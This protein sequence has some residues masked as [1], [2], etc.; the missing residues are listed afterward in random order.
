M[1]RWHAA[2]PP[3]AVLFDM[4]GVLVDTFDAWFEVLKSC[5]VRRGLSPIERA[6]IR[7]TWGQGIR[8]DCESFFP[9]ERPESLALEYDLVFAEHL[10]AVKAEP[11]VVSTV[12]RLRALGARTAVVTNSPVALARRIVAGIG[13]A[14]AF[15]AIAG[16][17]EVR[18]GKPEPEIVALA[19]A[20]IGAVS[21]S[22]VL[23]GDTVLDIAAARAAGVVSVGYKIDGADLRIEAIPELLGLFGGR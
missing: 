14:D 5:R 6:E 2:H 11:G 1:I 10:D 19:L 4:D 20:R 15:D 7:A 8:A 12:R 21:E 3:G 9:G 22:A 13:L 16:G 23:V 17:D 18:V